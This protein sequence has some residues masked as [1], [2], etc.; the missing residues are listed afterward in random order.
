MWGDSEKLG[1]ETL[2]KR[3]D[4]F[5]SDSLDKTVDGTLV[6]IALLVVYSCKNNIPRVHDNTDTDTRQGTGDQMQTGAFF[7]DVVV[8]QKAFGGVVNGQL[9]GGPGTCS[10]NSGVHAT[11]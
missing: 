11:V 8:E 3:A 9:H 10:E 4:T 2:V 5:D 6:K 7:H 1:L